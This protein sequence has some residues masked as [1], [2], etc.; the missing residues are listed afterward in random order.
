MKKSLLGVAFASLLATT[1]VAMATCPT[2]DCPQA[3]G[4]GEFKIDSGTYAYA[5]NNGPTFAGNA[6]SFDVT[7]NFSGVAK[8]NA[9]GAWTAIDEGH[10]LSE[11]GGGGWGNFNF[12]IGGQTPVCF[13]NCGN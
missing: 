12:T 1:G 2:N 4:W 8:F 10:G 3:G 5:G 9:N 13:T 6:G 11:S 7:A